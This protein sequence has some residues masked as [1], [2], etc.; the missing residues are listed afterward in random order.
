MR[1]YRCLLTGHV[2]QRCTAGEDCSDRC[3]RCGQ[4]GHKAARCVT[5]SPR[6]WYCA[7]ANR[8]SDH[9]IGSTKLCR[10]PK[11]QGLGLSVGIGSI[12]DPRVGDC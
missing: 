8:K 3:Y 12:L 5:P 6:C 2:G 11:G 10:L 9:G 7:A 1:C 4:G